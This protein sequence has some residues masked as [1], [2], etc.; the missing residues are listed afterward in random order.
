[1][2][3]PSRAASGS[4]RHQLYLLS[5]R[6]SK[7]VKDQCALQPGNLGCPAAARMDT[8]AES[9]PRSQPVSQNFFC[10]KHPALASRASLA[11]RPLRWTRPHTLSHPAPPRQH[12]FEN[13]FALSLHAAQ[14]A[15]QKRQAS[16]QKMP[17]TTKNQGFG[18]QTDAGLQCQRNH[19]F[20]ARR[21]KRTAKSP[22]VRYTL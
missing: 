7:A 3:I 14:R 6:Y 10:Y 2:A 9:R 5:F 20:R 21:R 16:T 11:G 8:L 4:K 18:N 22:A 15:F 12:C 13:K 1:M 17:K 19:D